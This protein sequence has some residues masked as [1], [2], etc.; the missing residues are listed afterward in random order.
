VALV[1]LAIGGA[2]A[3]ASATQR[4]TT[5]TFTIHLP[6]LPI[7]NLC[8]LDA[9][10]VSGDL[11]ITVTTTPRRDGGYTVRSTAAAWRLSGN[12]VFPEPQIGYKAADVEQSNTY[13]APP[14]SPA[15]STYDVHWTKLVPQGPA[16]TMYLVIVTR[17][18]VLSDGSTL[19]TPDP[20]RTYLVCTEPCRQ[21]AA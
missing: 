21:S 16:P 11:N 3:A 8:N 20:V 2:P 10:V 15:W 12:R 6:A 19:M 17:L 18:T 13:Y 1:L 9:V 7:D 4:G 14:P 5:T